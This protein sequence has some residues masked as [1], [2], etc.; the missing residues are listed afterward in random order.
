[1][2]IY[3]Y[4]M[5]VVLNLQVNQCSHFSPIPFKEGWIG[6]A[7]ELVDPKRILGDFSS[8]GITFHNHSFC[9]NL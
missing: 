6:C 9:Q 4:I 8:N 5:G 3:V 7:D 1:M 2:M